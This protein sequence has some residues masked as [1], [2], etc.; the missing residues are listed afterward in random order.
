MILLARTSFS[1]PASFRHEIVKIVFEELNITQ[2]DT[3]MEKL[4]RL[5]YSDDAVVKIFI[6][7]TICRYFPRGLEIISENITE[8]SVRN[9]KLKQI[10][11]LDL[12]PFAMLQKLI[13]DGNLLTSLEPRLFVFNPQLIHA[14][15]SDN[16]IRTISADIYDH[17]Q[18]KSKIELTGNVC[19]DKKT[20]KWQ[21]NDVTALIIDSCQISN[22]QVVDAC[23]EMHSEWMSRETSLEWIEN[24]T[25]MWVESLEDVIMNVAI[26]LMMYYAFSRYFAVKYGIQVDSSRKNK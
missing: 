19:I 2:P 9:S 12:E 7:N 24:Q 17:I 11:R 23:S 14:D 16:R 22:D 5:E 4:Q 25:G 6:Q 18:S 8:I 10:T 3:Q 1:E 20:T 26:I 13:L 15:F 21:T